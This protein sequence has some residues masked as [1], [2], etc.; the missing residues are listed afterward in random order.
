MNL[1]F[2]GTGASVPTKQRNMTSI[3]LQL[4]QERGT[5]FLIDAGEGTQHQMLHS[6]LR[7]SRLEKILI[8]HMH[9]DHILGLPGVLGSRATEGVTKPLTI[10][11][12]P[13]IQSFIDFFL[14]IRKSGLTYPLTIVEVQPGV[15]FE[16]HEMIITAKQL[17]H[18][19]PS[20]GYR[21]QEK[22]RPGELLQQ[23][24]KDDGIAQSPL[25]SRLKAGE[26]VT[27]PNGQTLHS[28]TYTGPPKR[29]HSVVICGDTSPTPA[30]IELAQQADVLVH[31]STY[32]HHEHVKALQRGHSTASHAAQTAL[33][34]KVKTLIITH[35]SARYDENA[36]LQLLLEA[37]SLFPHTY[38][39][40]DHFSYDI[41]DE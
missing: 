30:V 6:P 15:I 39:A 21:F 16:D 35:I 31:E 17:A 7:L 41:G 28:E 9:G 19:I 2:L 10:Y 34:A 3:A 24:L 40:N 4:Y 5:F 20:Y 23:K 29:G 14:T 26:D 38:L 11:G 22:D 1:Y 12:P 27:L 25:F 36:S 8:T 33:D 13:G 18:T 37:R 32:A